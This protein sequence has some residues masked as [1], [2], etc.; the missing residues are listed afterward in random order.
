MRIVVYGA[1]GFI[2][3]WLLKIAREEGHD[4]LA[5]DIKKLGNHIEFMGEKY[6]YAR[7]DGDLDKLAEIFEGYDAVVNL[8]AIRA[9]DDFT[10]TDYIKNIQIFDEVI[11]ACKKNSIRNIIYISSRAVYSD[12]NIPWKEKESNV[13]VSLY[14]ASKTAVD[15]LIEYY[16]STTDFSIKSLRLAQVLGIG[17]RSGY[18]LNTFIDKAYGKETLKLHGEGVGARQYI[19]I[20]DVAY[21][22]LNAIEHK[23]TKGIFNIGNEG[24]I[25]NK[26]L[27]VIINRVFDNEGNMEQDIDLSEDKS[28]SVMD[29]SKAKEVLGWESRYT[30][31]EALYDIKNIMN[32]TKETR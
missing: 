23:E 17:E 22:I 12:I 28:I 3:K 10:M 26:E 16:N 8:A 1:G 19:Y 5:V 21:S 29:I 31:E 20:K 15:M 9:T 18:M 7:A 14:G 6:D 32:T 13:P 25:S 11:Q 2:G 27:A 30:F 24:T 4:V